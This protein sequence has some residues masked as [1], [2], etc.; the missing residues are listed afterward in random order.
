MRKR[1][2]HLKNE[3]QQEKGSKNPQKRERK[4]EKKN[5]LKK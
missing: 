3:R 2:I 5:T 4:D 1:K